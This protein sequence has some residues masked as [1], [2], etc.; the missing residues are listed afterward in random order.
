MNINEGDR[1]LAVHPSDKTWFRVKGT[2]SYS[3]PKVIAT[4]RDRFG[5]SRIL[6]RTNYK[7]KNTGKKVC[8]WFTEWNFKKVA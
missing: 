7:D 2:K 4:E 1:V 8:K 3:C 5:N 6:V